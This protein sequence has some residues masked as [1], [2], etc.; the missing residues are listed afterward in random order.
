[1]DRQ[2]V[3]EMLLSETSSA[4][5]RVAGKAAEIRGVVFL[6]LNRAYEAGLEPDVICDLLGVSP[7]NVL[8]RANI[9]KSDETIVMNAYQA[10]DGILEQQYRATNRKAL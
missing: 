7:D 5:Q 4:L 3:I 1:M 6:Y 2:A 9:S 10:L 8:Q